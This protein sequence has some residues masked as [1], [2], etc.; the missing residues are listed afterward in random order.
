MSQKDGANRMGEIV[1][2]VSPA[3]NLNVDVEVVNTQFVD[4]EGVRVRA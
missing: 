2:L 4:P 1:S 3:T